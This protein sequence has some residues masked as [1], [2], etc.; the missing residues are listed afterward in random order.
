MATLVSVDGELAS[1]D[2][3]KSLMPALVGGLQVFRTMEQLREMF[4]PSDVTPQNRSSNLAEHTITTSSSSSTAPGN[5]WWPHLQ[6]AFRGFHQRSSSPIRSQPQPNHRH[7]RRLYQHRPQQ[8]YQ[9]SNVHGTVAN[10]SGSSKD[11]A[12]QQHLA[13]QQET[14]SWAQVAATVAAGAV[15]RTLAQMA[16]HP[17]DT[18]KTR[19][20]VSL[21]N[22]QLQMWRAVMYC[23][24]T[25]PQALLAWARPAGLRDVYLG[26]AAAVA[27]TLPASAVYFTTEQAVR[28]WLGRTLQLDSEGAP[29]RLTA[30]AT[31]AC[32]AALV[33]VP[34]DV[35]K[36]RVQAYAYPSA[37]HAIRDILATKGPMGLYSGFGASMLRDA[38]E[39]VIQFTVYRQLKSLLDH[40]KE[41]KSAGGGG[42]ATAGGGLAE[43]ILLGGAAGAAAALTTTPL[44][45]V[46]TQMLCGT[47]KSV[48]AALTATVRAGGPAALFNG[49]APRLLQTTLCSAI[50]F[51]CFETSKA[52]LGLLTAAATPLSSMAA[53]STP[54]PPPAAAVAAS[55]QRTT[56]TSSAPPPP[57]PQRW[58]SSVVVY[59]RRRS[60]GGGAAGA[61]TWL[62]GA[63]VGGDLGPLAP[64]AAYAYAY[65][66]AA[67]PLM[68][69]GGALVDSRY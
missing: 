7:H 53:T 51:T 43:S 29:C 18:L 3:Q 50:F 22:P 2:L 42:A 49:L 4:A 61:A 38:P 44:D 11:H 26:L 66:G 40:Q 52:R 54:P 27:G 48:A 65:V 15:S 30:S 9:D 36:H 35:V 32:L 17:L 31:A 19:L 6:G 20:Q 25:R 47:A 34:A 13:Q 33:R 23:S 14:E 67:A 68:T 45:V 16:I 28:K 37:I 8:Q 5:S 69:S 12:A 21:C 46:R 58:Q 55:E 39:L 24:D 41:K 59:G 1:D 10:N 60:S 57:P 62:N 64:V 63:G 56:A